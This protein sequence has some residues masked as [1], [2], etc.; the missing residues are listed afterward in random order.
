MAAARI[1]VLLVAVVLTAGCSGLL[2]G[3]EPAPVTTYVFA[4]DLPPARPAANGPAIAVSPP[5]AAAGYGTRR[6]AY[7]ESNYRIDYFAA[8]EWVGTP[9]D[10]LL[11][12]LGRALRSTGRFRAVAEDARGVETD[13]RLDTLIVQLRQDFRRRPSRGSVIVR[14]HL[15]DTKRRRILA[16]GRFEGDVPAPRD[17]PYGGVVAI[18]QALSQVLGQ[19]AAFAAGG[20]TG[21]EP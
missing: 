17:D 21:G 18:N 7:L 10:M 1:P 5:E 8:N 11:P 15:V 14:A 20:P 13:L 3:P 9:S 12:L 6:M 4:P 2:L 19:I 16:T